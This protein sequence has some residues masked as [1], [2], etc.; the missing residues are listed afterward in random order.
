MPKKKLPQ[1][2]Y[3]PFEGCAFC[4]GRPSG[5]IG[6]K[7][8]RQR[9]EYNAPEA[10]AAREAAATAEMNK[11]LLF[12]ARFD[13]PEEMK[14]LRDVFSAEA[15]S[16][17]FSAQ[18]ISDEDVLRDIGRGSVE[19]GESKIRFAV[20]VAAFTGHDDGRQV[21]IA[22]R[23]REMAAQRAIA[24]LEANLQGRAGANPNRTQE[25]PQQEQPQTD[26]A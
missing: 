5:C 17:A 8:E 22:N 20:A 13:N 4:K 11:H 14:T 15:V 16:A 3:E 1:I 7:A 24:T 21:V 2:S 6:C 23:R 25:Q 12:S 9:A 26:A 10:R 18:D 19:E